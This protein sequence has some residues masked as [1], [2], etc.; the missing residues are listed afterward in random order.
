MSR[1]ARTGTNRRRAESLSLPPMNSTTERSSGPRRA[2]AFLPLLL[3]CTAALAG[4]KSADA[5]AGSAAA[6]SGAPT[7]K[8]AKLPG[9]P[10]GKLAAAYLRVFNSG[11]RDSLRDFIAAD[12]S[13]LALRDRSL[14]TR[15][16]HH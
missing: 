11:D 15:T 14:E 4:A 12:Y 8:E 9:T 16:A 1:A 13:E 6:P 3:L 2:A 5:Q 10:L 7:I